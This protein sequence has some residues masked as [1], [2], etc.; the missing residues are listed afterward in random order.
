[1]EMDRKIEHPVFELYW[2]SHATP[3]KV[4]EWLRKEKPDFTIFGDRDE[5]IEKMLIGRHEPMIK[6]GLALYACM[7]SDTALS[8]FRNCD[9]TIKK[10]VLAGPSVSSSPNWIFG[11]A[12]ILK[13]LLQSFDDNIELLGFLFSNESIS[14]TLLTSLYERT[15]P[16]NNLTDEH[17][18]RAIELTISNPALSN[19]TYR[20]IHLY[21]I[22]K[23]MPIP[24]YGAEDVFYNA[25]KLF[26]TVPVSE[27]SV[28]ILSRLGEILAPHGEGLI[29]SEPSHMDV[30]ATIRRWETEGEDKYGWYRK[31]RAALGRLLKDDELR[32]NDD[33][34]MRQAYYAG[35]LWHWR[36]PEEVRE[37]FEKDK[38]GFLEVAIENLSFFA[39]EHVRRELRQCC[40]DFAFKDEYGEH[41]RI[42]PDMYCL[43]RFDFQSDRLEQEHP[44]WYPD[45]HGDFPIHKVGNLSDRADK[46]LALLQRQVKAI[47]RELIGTKSED[48][49]SSWYDEDKA[50]LIENIKTTLD[51]ANQLILSKLAS[52]TA[53]MVFAGIVFAII[54]IVILIKL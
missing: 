26:N 53:W 4:I 25:W 17:W 30:L 52:V 50:S 36:K 54:L 23:T 34:A 16:F 37:A 10:A 21:S 32:D 6:L 13:E 29:P 7:T 8:F 38:A 40:H 2:L 12:G 1:M 43:N 22:D 28:R 20:D 33:I 42:S 46:R 48:D 27:D 15:Y 3:D 31:C 51:Q 45:S 35:D 41:R 47:S 11:E 19:S 5:E 44:E 14:I 49:N 9:A 39:N 18:I 24:R